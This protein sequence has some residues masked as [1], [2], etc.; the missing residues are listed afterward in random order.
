LKLLIPDFRKTAK[1]AKAAKAG[2]IRGIGNSLRHDD[3]S[4]PWDVSALYVRDTF[5]SRVAADTV[6]S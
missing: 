4:Q 5:Q 2:P 1:A 6:N 3:I